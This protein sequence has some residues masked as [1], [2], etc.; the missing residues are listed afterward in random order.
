MAVTSSVRVRHEAYS[1]G[2]LILL[3]GRR[4]GQFRVL[5]RH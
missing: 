2:Q 4:S 3:R 1:E 5:P